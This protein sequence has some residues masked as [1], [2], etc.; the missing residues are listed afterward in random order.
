MSVWHGILSRIS[1]YTGNINAVKL[2]CEDAGLAFNVNVVKSFQI[3]EK[4]IRSLKNKMIV[5]LREQ[6]SDD[7]GIEDI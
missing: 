7:I 4:G 5:F 6:Y 2:C 3:N 1:H